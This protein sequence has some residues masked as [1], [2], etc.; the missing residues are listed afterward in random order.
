MD[1]RATIEDPW[2]AWVR[3]AAEAR[4]FHFVAV[5]EMEFT[6]AVPMV[7]ASLRLGPV[8]V[9][10][11][12]RDPLWRFEGSWKGHEE[13]TVVGDASHRHRRLADGTW[14]MNESLGQVDSAQ[15]K[16]MFC[17][18][19]AMDEVGQLS[20]ADDSTGPERLWVVTGEGL[21]GK[22]QVRARWWVTREG[23]AL[24]RLELS[25]ATF[26]EWGGRRAEMPMPS[27]SITYESWEFPAEIPHERFQVPADAVAEEGESEGLEQWLE[28]LAGEAPDAG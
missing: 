4:A 1:K 15:L 19:D 8:E 14:V 21:R 26:F 13:V 3:R 17:G 20:V 6:L 28:R 25:G 5:M 12:Y 22:R 18:L 24:R 10:A 9:E 16:R 7:P 2:T 11:W 23:L 27:L